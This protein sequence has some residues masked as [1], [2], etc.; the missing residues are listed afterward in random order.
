M[1]KPQV[2]LFLKPVDLL[3]CFIC[4]HFRFS[5]GVS[6]THL[7]SVALFF[8]S[9]KFGT[10]LKVRGEFSKEPEEGGKSHLGQDVPERDVRISDLCG[11]ILQCVQRFCK[12]HSVWLSRPALMSRACLRCGP[13]MR[14][15]REV[16]VNMLVV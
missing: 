9:A 4:D 15:G 8:L 12:C 10:A 11:Y 3:T 13:S 6:P 5:S 7:D 2:R 14:A 1:F 16:R